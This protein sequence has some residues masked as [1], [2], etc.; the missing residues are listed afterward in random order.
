LKIGKPLKKRG[1]QTM[2][3]RII[4]RKPATTSIATVAT[5]TKTETTETTSTEITTSTSTTETFT[6][7]T[8]L[9]TLARFVETKRAKIK[10][11]HG[12]LVAKTKSNGSTG[13]K[14][15]EID[16]ED[17]VQ[18]TYIRMAVELGRKPIENPE[19]LFNL[20]FKTARFDQYRK[21]STADRFIEFSTPVAEI[22]LE[23]NN[24]T[25]L[26]QEFYVQMAETLEY[27]EKTLK[28][29][30]FD[31]FKMYHLEQSTQTEI[32][33]TLGMEKT[34]ISMAIKRLNNRLASLGIVEIIDCR[35]AAPDQY[36]VPDIAWPQYQEPN[37]APSI[38]DTAGIESHRRLVQS[39]RDKRSQTRLNP[40]HGDHVPLAK[41]DFY[42]ACRFEQSLPETAPTRR[43][44]FD[45][46]IADLN[47]VN[48]ECTTAQG[49]KRRV[50]AIEA[51]ASATNNVDL[52]AILN[53][54]RA[55]EIERLTVFTTVKR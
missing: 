52:A 29:K 17:V 33:Q 36:Q 8:D 31:L 10:R 19:H 22:E 1:E 39:R 12:G 44:T 51:A 47:R 13:G 50:A 26:N 55:V 40:Y 28:P 15:I 4:I 11:R 23:K 48:R 9:E 32:G 20:T 18:E 45:S 30:Q 21:T 27:I 38:L 41:K 43:T 37:G 42:A 6:A 34:A 5:A 53:T 7:I 3:K 16:L 54:W 24:S 25:N 49:I 2:A 14:K 35:F 46:W